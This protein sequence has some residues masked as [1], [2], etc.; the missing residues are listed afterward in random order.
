[1]VYSSMLNFTLIGTRCRPC[2]VKSSKYDQVLNFGDSCTNPPSPIS[3]KFAYKNR[4]MC[5]L[6]I[7]P[8]FTGIGSSCRRPCGQ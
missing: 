6:P 8:D 4:P 7:M 3:E 2:G 1:M 5:P